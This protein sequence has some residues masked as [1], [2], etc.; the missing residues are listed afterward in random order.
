[1]S[2]KDKIEWAYWQGG[3]DDG[4]WVAVDKSV[5]MPDGI[6]KQIG[7][8][9]TPDPA[10]GFYCMYDAGRLLGKQDKDKRPK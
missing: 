2:Q 1:M 3:D 4:T 8:E 10:T 6:E 5:V 9:G 7:F